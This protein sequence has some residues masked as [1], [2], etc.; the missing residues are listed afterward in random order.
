M[1]ARVTVTLSTYMTV[2]TRRSSLTSVRLNDSLAAEPSSVRSRRCQ[3]DAYALTVVGSSPPGLARAADFF[4]SPR[5]AIGRPFL[6]SCPGKYAFKWAIA[7]VTGILVKNLVGPA[8]AN[9]GRPRASPHGRI[10]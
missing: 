6:G 10:V 2:Q 1:D 9:H 5:G 8:Q 3:P 4:L 7:L